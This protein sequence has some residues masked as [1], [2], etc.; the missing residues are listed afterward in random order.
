MPL[1][2]AQGK[3][4]ALEGLRQRREAAKEQKDIN[5]SSLPAG[6]PMFYYC[7]GCGLQNIVLP[8]AHLQMPPKLCTE[9]QAMLDMG[10]MT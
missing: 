7:N 9:C 5:N 8:E 10:W 4:A 1:L 2:T 6:S 3:E